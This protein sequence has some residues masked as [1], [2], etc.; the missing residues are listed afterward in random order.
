LVQ[1]ELDRTL[2]DP[3]RISITGENR[4]DYRVAGV[5]ALNLRMAAFN[6]RGH[7]GY[8]MQIGRAHV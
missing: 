8:E 7:T 4:R 3:R 2:P 5:Q 6:E 1:W